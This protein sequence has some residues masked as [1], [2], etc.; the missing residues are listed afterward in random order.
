MRIPLP[1]SVSV[2][3]TVFPEAESAPDC[4]LGIRRCA[5]LQQPSRE[6]DPPLRGGPKKLAVL[7]HRQGCRVQCNCILSGG[8]SE[9]QRNWS[10]PLPVLYTV[11]TALLRKNPHPTNAW[12]PWCLGRT[13]CSSAIMRNFRL[14]L[15]NPRN[16]NGQIPKGTWPWFIWD[17]LLLSGYV[18]SKQRYPIVA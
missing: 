2:K 10:L 17:G 11:S 12:K 8:N 18:S 9:G 6:C 5:H 1:Y 7:R 13:K 4:I 14:E 16:T 15:N 3:P